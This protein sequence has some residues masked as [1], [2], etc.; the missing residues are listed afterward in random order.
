MNLN[1]IFSAKR[2]S[3][4]KDELEHKNNFLLIQKLSLK[5]GVIEIATRNA[6]ASELDIK[7]DTFIS[8]QSFGYWAK[9]INEKSIHNKILNLKDMDF[10]K[11]AS[12]NRKTSLRNFYKVRICY[13]LLVKTRNRAFHF[14][15]LYKVKQIIGGK[16][17]FCLPRISTL[18]N[19]E[20]IGI[21]P[22]NLEIFLDDILD[23]FDKDLKEYLK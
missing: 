2:L 16:S 11:Y 6:V 10:R 12:S 23:C 19:G 20:V 4:Y 21:M 17:T 1:K 8:R 13:D 15:N 5:L 22:Q 14:E 18:R 9:I 7:D 3:N